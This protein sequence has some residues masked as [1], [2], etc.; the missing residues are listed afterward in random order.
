M[1]NQEESDFNIVIELHVKGFGMERHK[2]QLAE[3]ILRDAQVKYGTNVKAFLVQE[4][5]DN[6]GR[7][8]RQ[9]LRTDRN[10]A[11]YDAGFATQPVRQGE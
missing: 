11:S 6:N 1:A 10:G 8:K 5:G 3:T 4:E 9:V 7:V 2:I